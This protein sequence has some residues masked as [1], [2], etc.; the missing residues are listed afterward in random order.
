MIT[1]KKL[2]LYFRERE[3]LQIYFAAIYFIALQFVPYYC[4]KRLPTL[5]AIAFSFFYP[6]EHRKKAKQAV[7]SSAA[8]TTLNTDPP[9]DQVFKIN[10]AEI[11]G[12]RRPRVCRISCVTY[13]P[14]PPLF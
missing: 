13:T 6:L 1:G 14:N 9:M 8:T 11:L 7:Y 2:S 10:C 12:M 5:L 3:N 4:L